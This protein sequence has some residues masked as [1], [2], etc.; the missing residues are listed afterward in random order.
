MAYV[1][2]SALAVGVNQIDEQHKELFR[3]INA[4]IDAASQGK[5][6]GEIGSVVDFLSDYV[7]S[8]F[9]DEEKL[10][11]KSG[12]PGYQSHRA[13]HVKFMQ[14]FTTLKKE[15]AQ[16][17]ATSAMVIAVQRRVGD[18]LVNHI[19]KTDKELG[20]YLAQK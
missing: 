15:F 8:H 3:R 17:G 2:T 5:G 16:Q 18:W 7:V 11:I 4:L 1:W 20:S 10:Q 13:A 12:Y 9:R 6:K 19:Y 14:D